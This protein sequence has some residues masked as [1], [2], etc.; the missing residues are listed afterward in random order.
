MTLVNSV[1]M[2]R[3][4]TTWPCKGKGRHPSS[5]SSG[6]ESWSL[7]KSYDLF[8]PEDGISCIL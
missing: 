2:S 3:Y 7:C 5:A 1:L 8:A 6:A 4:W